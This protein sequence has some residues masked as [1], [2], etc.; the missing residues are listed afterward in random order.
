MS[1]LQ[2]ITSDV[3]AGVSHLQGALWRGNTAEARKLLQLFLRNLIELGSCKLP[4]QPRTAHLTLTNT[5]LQLVPACNGC[6][7]SHLTSVT[8]T[9]D[10]LFLSHISPVQHFLYMWWCSETLSACSGRCFFHTQSKSESRKRKEQNP[11]PLAAA[12][13]I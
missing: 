3:K 13:R 5:I 9:S 7:P 8:K 12:G 10:S 4:L 2:T 11:Q 6:W 1:L